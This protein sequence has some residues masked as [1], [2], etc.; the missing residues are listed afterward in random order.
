M[1][2]VLVVSW[3]SHQGLDWVSLTADWGVTRITSRIVKELSYGYR[4]QLVWIVLFEMY[5]CWSNFSKYLR[6]VMK[7]I[8]AHCRRYIWL[9]TNVITKRALVLGDKLCSFICMALLNIIN[10]K[11]WNKA[12]IFKCYW[13][14]EHK[15]DTT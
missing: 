2:C 5:S 7:I 6:R 11:L 4:I 13:D 9:C 3:F 12:V 15:Q 8:E 14:L 10:L 1:N